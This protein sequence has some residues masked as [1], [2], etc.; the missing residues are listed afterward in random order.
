LP[1]WWKTL[2]KILKTESGRYSKPKFGQKEFKK[3]G[4][5]FGAKGRNWPLAIRKSYLT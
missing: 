3:D 5:Q 1:K 2:R 4:Q